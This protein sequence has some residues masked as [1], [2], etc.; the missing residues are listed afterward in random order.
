MEKLKRATSEQWLKRY[1]WGQINLRGMFEDHR[2]HHD[3]EEET[4]LECCVTGYYH[5]FPLM[6]WNPFKE[7][8]RINPLHYSTALEIRNQM[9]IFCE[10]SIE[11]LTE[12]KLRVK[13]L[14]LLIFRGVEN[15]MEPI[16]KKFLATFEKDTKLVFRKTSTTLPE[17]FVF[18][19]W[20]HLFNCPQVC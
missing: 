8:I 18:F 3:Y 9:N 4:F 7:V 13:E 20:M 19:S 11:S 16:I 2:G 6:M 14:S 10:C 17:P 5:Y 1:N 12:C 15:E